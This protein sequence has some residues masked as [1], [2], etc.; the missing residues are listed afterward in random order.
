MPT[1]MRHLVPCIACVYRVQDDGNVVI[2]YDLAGD[3][4][5]MTWQMDCQWS[6][7]GLIC[8]MIWED[9]VKTKSNIY[10]LSLPMGCVHACSHGTRRRAERVSMWVL[11]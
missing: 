10:P 7:C 6:L 5:R 9:V 11:Y 1:L 4:I 3:H 8:A 2:R